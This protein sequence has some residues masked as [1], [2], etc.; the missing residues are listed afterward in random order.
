MTPEDRAVRKA[1]DRITQQPPARNP[2]QN[3]ECG[4]AS[5][6]GEAGPRMGRG[7]AAPVVF[8]S[9]LDEFK[10]HRE[11]TWR[12]KLPHVMLWTQRAPNGIRRRYPFMGMAIGPLRFTWRGAGHHESVVL[13]HERLQRRQWWREF[14]YGCLL[15]AF[16]LAGI[17]VFFAVTS[18][19]SF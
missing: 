3:G 8:P 4:M 19:R 17:V 9:W 10:V 13:E 15:V 1:P 2:A 12:F 5:D 14:V 11:L 16:A 6:D 7:S 18:M